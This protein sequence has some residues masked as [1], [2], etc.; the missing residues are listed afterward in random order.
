MQ[1]QTNSVK[2]GALRFLYLN[3]YSFLLL[4][5]SILFFSVPLYKISLY[6][7]FVQIP[8][9]LYVLSRSVKLFSTW[10][11]KK[12]KYAVLMAKNQGGFRE[13]SFAV[14]MQAPCGRLLVK[15]VLKDL[16][17]PNQYKELKKYKKT[18]FSAVRDSCK[19]VKT[20][21]YINKDFL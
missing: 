10:N 18:F 11:E 4:L 21:V 2:F 8:F 15:T 19:P 12:R 20:T 16:G 6:F 1:S 9:G 13:E 5:L 7:L 17:M 14:F 3:A